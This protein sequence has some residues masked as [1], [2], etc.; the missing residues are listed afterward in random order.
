MKSA[1]RYNTT[2]FDSPNSQAAD[3]GD[4]DERDFDLVIELND[5]ELTHVAGGSH[6]PSLVGG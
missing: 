5:F 2:T 4:R 1:N 6:R 3:H